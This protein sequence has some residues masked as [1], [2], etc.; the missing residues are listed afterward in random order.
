[1]KK[2]LARECKGNSRMYDQAKMF[3]AVS[4][5]DLGFWKMMEVWVHPL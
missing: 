3:D 4:F 1:M 2:V 5:L